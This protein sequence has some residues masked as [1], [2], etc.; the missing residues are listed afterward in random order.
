MAEEFVHRPVI[1]DEVLEALRPRS[2][3]RYVDGTLGGGNHAAAILS[4]SAPNGFLFGSDRDSSA[5]EAARKRLAEFQG[6]F[7][8]RQGKFSELADWVEQGS[9]DGVL[10]DLGVS[11]PQ[12]DRPERG[13]SF[14]QGPLDMRMDTRQS[15]TAAD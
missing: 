7:E 14:Q 15:T 6:R 9:C 3:G 13:F 5:V 11:S 2:G 4:A 10:L 8:I 12:L 1:V